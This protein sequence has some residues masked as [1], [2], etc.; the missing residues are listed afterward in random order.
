MQLRAASL[1]ASAHSLLPPPRSRTSQISPHLIHTSNLTNQ[2]DSPAL[3]TILRTYDSAP[4]E[5][6]D[7]AR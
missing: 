5:E 2:S 6:E 4:A 3:R 7:F 1:Q